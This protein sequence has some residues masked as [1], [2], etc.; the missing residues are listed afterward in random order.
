MSNERKSVV[1]VWGKKKYTKLIVCV[2]SMRLL[3]T[4]GYFE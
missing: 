3:A 4:A 1:K 2:Y